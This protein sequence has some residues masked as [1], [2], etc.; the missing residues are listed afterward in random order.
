LA[1]CDDGPVSPNDKTPEALQ[2]ENL[3]VAVSR[4]LGGDV[5]LHD[6]NTWQDGGVQTFCGFAILRRDKTDHIFLNR[7]GRV[8]LRGDIADTEFQRLDRTGC[9]VLHPEGVP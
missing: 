1:A 7:Q 8:L 9:G 5:D 6:L 3:R 4:R 2:Q